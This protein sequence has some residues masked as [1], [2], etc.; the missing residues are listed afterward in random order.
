MRS[1]PWDT[2]PIPQSV[3]YFKTRKIGGDLNPTGLPAYWALDYESNKAVYIEYPRP[4]HKLKRLKAPVFKALTTRDISL[5]NGFNA[6]AVILIEDDMND[7]FYEMCCD[8]VLSI[9]DFPAEMTRTILIQRLEKWKAL[10]SGSHAGLSK[11]SQRGLFA[12]LLFI[13]DHVLPTVSEMQAIQGWVGPEYAPQDFRFGQTGVE[14]K[15]KHGSSKHKVKI[16]SE[17]QL[18]V[19]ESER[20]FLCVTEI[21]ES[22]ND[23]GLSLSDL[24]RRINRRLSFAPARTLFYLKLFAVG[25]DQNVDYDTT[26][27]VGETQFYEVLDGFP[28]IVD[29]QNGVSRISYVVD[30]E[31]CKDY[32]IDAQSVRKSMRGL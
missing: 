2:M 11:E 23:N 9:Q 30:L 27:T 5:E 14:V 25:Y 7:I 28:R 22:N 8:L 12:E 31:Y 15:S 29:A 19:N 24:V 18:K 3:A 10:M 20:L 26:W 1:S 21:N 4:K 17:D 32:E 16:S 6:F 13:E